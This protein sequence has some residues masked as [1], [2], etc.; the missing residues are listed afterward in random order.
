M[1]NPNQL[2]TLFAIL[3]AVAFS[4][5]G[6]DKLLAKA[7]RRRVSEKALLLASA[8]AASPGALLGMVVFNH[9]TSKPKFRYGVPGLLIAHAALSYWLSYA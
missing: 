3:N 1:P 7:S 2:I 5:F 6:I 9:K 8:V 4:L